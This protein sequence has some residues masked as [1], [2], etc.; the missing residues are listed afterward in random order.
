MNRPAR[1]EAEARTRRGRDR[2]IDEVNG[3]GKRAGFVR[4]GKADAPR[5]P[6]CSRS[7][8]AYLPHVDE[9]RRQPACAQDI[10]DTVGGVPLGDAVQRDRGA[11][12]EE[13]H[14]LF[15]H[16][17][18]AAAHFRQRLR[19]PLGRRTVGIRLFRRE[20]FGVE[21]PQRLDGGIER[22]VGKVG[23]LQRGLEQRDHVGL[24]SDQDAA[25]VQGADGGIRPVQAELPLQPSYLR[26][27]NLDDPF[28]LL[29][30]GMEDVDRH[31]RAERRSAPAHR[32]AR[33]G[34]SSAGKKRRA[35]GRS[36]DGDHASAR[37]IC[38]CHRKPRQLTRT[39]GRSCPV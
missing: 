39:P 1:I 15:A 37:E 36:C 25:P 13:R 9:G 14:A 38:W 5:R 26:Q 22:A 28:G 35:C 20:V 2:A 21:L 29:P 16:A 17:Q 24:R 23:E 30:I 34:A 7:E 3:F 18:A 32:L 12:P 11:T 10:H 19:Q 4:I 31:L 33:P 27:A 8:R 6:V